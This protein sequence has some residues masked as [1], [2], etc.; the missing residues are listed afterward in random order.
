MN[1]LAENE[2]AELQKSKLPKDAPFAIY[3]V[4]HSQFSIARYYG[5]ATYNGMSYTYF[6]EHDQLIRD[7]VLRWTKKHR[8][9]AN[10]EKAKQMEL[11]A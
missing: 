4:S 6:P 3:D 7:D 8:G 11:G 5:G 2:I 9:Q 10:R 1:Y